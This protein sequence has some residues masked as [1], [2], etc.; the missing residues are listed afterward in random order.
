MNGPQTEENYLESYNPGDYPPVA[1]AADLVVFAVAGSVLHVALVRRG[2]HPFRD[3]LALP[4]GFVG[5]RES[6]EDAARRELAEETGLDLG[7]LLVHIE[8]L[9]TYSAPLRD[10]RM[11]VVSTAHLVLLATNGSTL[12]ALAGAGDA[13]DAGWYPAH[14]ILAGKPG[15]QLAFDHSV[16]LLDGLNRLAGKMEYTTVATQL[17]PGEFTLTQLRTVYEAVWNSPMAPGNF[18]R[19]MTP[20]LEDT[21]QKTRTAGGGAPATLFRATDRHIHPPLARPRTP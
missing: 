14:E 21:G 1:L 19:K 9:A 20:Q 8:Q 5:P 18:T 17:L 11:R 4:G 12:P 15:G 7:G 10:P 2:T 16:I 6:A 3:R 13:A